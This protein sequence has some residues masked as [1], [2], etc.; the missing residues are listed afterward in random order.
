MTQSQQIQAQT[1]RKLQWREFGLII[2]QID[3][4]PPK[5]A[6]K[7]C[8]LVYFDLLVTTSGLNHH[9]LTLKITLHQRTE[10]GQICFVQQVKSVRTVPTELPKLQLCAA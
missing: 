7:G 3:H 8:H 1:R 4:F 6:V 2:R 9:Y 10:K 5:N